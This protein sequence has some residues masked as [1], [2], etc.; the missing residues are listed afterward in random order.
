MHANDLLC[1]AGYNSEE[2]AILAVTKRERQEGSIK[3]AAQQFIENKETKVSLV[4][5]LNLTSVPDPEKDKPTA[6]LK[7]YA[8]KHPLPFDKVLLHFVKNIH[9]NNPVGD[10]LYFDENG[11]PP[12]V[13]DI[14][15]WQLAPDGANKYVYIGIFD[16]RL[17]DDQRLTIHD[18]RVWWGGG[19]LQVRYLHM[20]AEENTRF[21]FQS[22]CKTPNT[23]TFQ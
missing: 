1:D 5:P 20:E 2:E 22:N 12:H 23:E 4:L 3:K 11:D 18:D 14:L 7:M 17:P 6:D 8:K 15:N 16:S 13:T 9:F 21:W 10:D 19:Y